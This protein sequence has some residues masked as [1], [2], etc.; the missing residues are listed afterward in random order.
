MKVNVTKHQVQ[1]QPMHSS[2][3]NT[4]GTKLKCTCTE[5]I[6]S[7]VDKFLRPFYINS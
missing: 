5:E 3:S 7:I 1:L 2:S 6:Q 4:E